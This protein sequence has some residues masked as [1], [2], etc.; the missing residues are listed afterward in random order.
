MLKRQ[1]SIQEAQTNELQLKE[2]VDEQKIMQDE[3][4]K[5][6]IEYLNRSIEVLLLGLVVKFIAEVVKQLYRNVPMSK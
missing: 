4:C 1:R 2:L 5:A 3:K 6:R